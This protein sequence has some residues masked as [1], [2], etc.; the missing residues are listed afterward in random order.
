MTTSVLHLKVR[1]QWDELD[2][3]RQEAV[4]FLRQHQLGEATINAT[5]MVVCELTENA[6]KYGTFAGPPNEVRI[7]VTV[8]GATIT[9]EVRSPVSS[10][11]DENL[12]KLD[13]AVQ[14]IRGFQNPFEAY[15]E[16]LKEVSAQS[17]ESSESGLGLVRIAYEGQSILDFFLHDQNVLAV[18]AVHRSQA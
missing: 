9:V 8:Q 4:S 1:P 10:A 6:T 2:V 13:R 5:E 16:R 12:Q 3:A 7:A 14:W 11:D 17:L 18:S 15:V